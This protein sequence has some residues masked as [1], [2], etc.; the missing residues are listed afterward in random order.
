MPVDAAFPR[1]VPYPHCPLPPPI[2][3][4][5]AGVFPL[6]G[7]PGVSRVI[8]VGEPLFW[9]G[10]VDLPRPLLVVPST[11]GWR[12]WWCHYSW[13]HAR[14][15]YYLVPSPPF[16][17]PAPDWRWAAFCAV[18]ELFP[19]PG[20]RTP[21]PSLPPH[22]PHLRCGLH[23]DP[24]PPP[25]HGLVWCDYLFP[26]TCLACCILLCTA[27]RFAVF[28]LSIGGFC[29]GRTRLL[30]CWAALG[31]CAV[32][33]RRALLRVTVAHPQL[34]VIEC[35]YSLVLIS[36]HI[37]AAASLPAIVGNSVGATRP[38]TRCY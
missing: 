12:C 3:V 2:Q 15:V 6:P 7:A 36:F 20:W 25:P 10:A 26:V 17:I 21:A 32:I 30:R 1:C 28:P 11:V 35:L 22:H 31:C 4:T 19:H 34:P 13:W 18:G 5:V 9:L 29:I 24:P 23:P 27:R 14:A 16:W 37:R 38:Q 8:G 33:F